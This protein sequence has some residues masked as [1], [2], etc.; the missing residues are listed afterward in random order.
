MR[1]VDRHRYGRV[2]IFEPWQI[3]APYLSRPEMA[4]VV[5]EGEVKV[6]SFN[7]SW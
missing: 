6:D 3:V 2:V 7:V 1:P 4:I 5:F